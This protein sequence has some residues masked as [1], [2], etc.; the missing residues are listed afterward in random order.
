[1]HD[2]VHNMLNFRIQSPKL[3]LVIL[4]INFYCKPFFDSKEFQNLEIKDSF[5]EEGGGEGWLHIV[6]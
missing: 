4:K 3:F 2:I 1:M 6:N 5:E